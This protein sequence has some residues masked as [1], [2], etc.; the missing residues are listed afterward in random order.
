[1]ATLAGNSIASS[2]TSLLKLD[3]NTDSTAAGNG[4]NA[5]QVKTG[6]ND[7]TPLYLNTDRLG[8]GTANVESLLHVQSDTA[9]QI[10]IHNT[11]SGN[12]PKFLFD[13]L[14]GTNADYVLGSLRASWDTHTNIVSEIRFESGNDTSNKDDGQI[15]FWTSPS[16]STV[17]ERLR[18]DENGNI[19]VSNDNPIAKMDIVGTRTINLTN[20][21]SDDTNK[22]AVITHSQYDSGTETEG[23]M[24]MQGFSSSSTN[25]IDIGGGNS[26]HNAT[27][28]IKFHTAAD[29]T[30][31]TGTARMVIDNNS[32][33]SLSNNDGG[34]DNTVFG[35]LAG[36]ALT[37]DGD[38]NV[39]IGHEAG[40]DMTTGERNVVIGYQAGDKMTISTRSVAIG[41]GALGTED[42]GD[43]SI[44]IGFNALNQQNSDSNNETTGNVG[45]GVEAGFYNQTGQY[46]TLIGTGAGLGASGQSNNNNTAV[47]YASLNVVTTGSNNT[48]IGRLAGDA[49][50]SGSSNIVIG[51]SAL[52][53]ATTATLNVAIGGD[54]MSLVPASVAIQD[55]VAIGQNAFKGSASTTTGA[56]GIVAIGRDSLKSLTT[57]TENTA[58]GYQSADGLTTGGYNTFVGYKVANGGT[59]TGLENTAMGVTALQQLTS[60]GQNTAVGVRAGLAMATGS[61]NVFIGKDAGDSATACSNVIAIGHNA[62]HTVSDST[63]VDGTIAIGESALDALTSGARNLAIGYRSGTALTTQTDNIAIG[64]DSL[65]SLNT[66]NAARNIAIGSYAMENLNSWATDNIAIGYEA[67]EGS[68]NANDIDYNIA[69]GSYALD[70]IGNNGVGGCVAVGYNALTDVNNS[71]A[72]GTI[73]IGYNAGSNI[74]NGARNTIV[75]YEGMLDSAGAGDNAVFGY[76]VLKEGSTAE[77]QTAMGAYA[78]GAASAAALT[79]N[80][81]TAIGYKALTLLQGSSL[82]NTAVGSLTLENCTTG[83]KNTTLGYATMAQCV[84]TN[85]CVAIG[86]YAM[87]AGDVAGDGQVAVGYGA[88]GELTGGTKNTSLGYQAGNL[89]T[90]GDTNIVIGY[91]ADVDNNNRNGCIVIGCE[92]TLNTASDNVVEIG[93]DTNSMTYDLDGGD[94]T[95][96]SDVRTKMNIEDSKIGLD[97]I[98]SLRPVTYETK[99]SA[100]YPKEFGVKNPVKKKSGKKWDGLIAQE[101]KQVMDDMGVEFSGWSE[102]LNTKQTLAYG[103]LIMP[104]I[105]SVQELSAKVEELQSKLK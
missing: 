50:T 66:T 59:I 84:D 78:L 63:A 2:Y 51:D 105:K 86:R 82:E 27:E 52:G 11:S 77:R 64:Y 102:G 21:T 91:D 58:I 62:M 46:N 38:E 23:F 3:G 28:E 32:R 73:A 45:I 79:G 12:A 22:N 14:V 87:G 85:N 19:G 101:V 61:A 54:C 39:L 65:L 53:T 81:N 42:V 25:R 36:N 35:K 92:L 98:N 44:A 56:D 72:Y 69:I 9:A 41:Y 57:G 20:T 93:N 43:R 95:V 67:M 31:A 4:S 89:I 10:Q 26:Q 15:T 80:E 47:G 34:A 76:Q 5:I 24:L 33:I 96:T 40:N 48:V 18:I 55:V 30:T 49:I 37:T 97:F 99:P 1:M 88:L 8:I 68:G 60:G 70:D 104:L 7:A 83:Q 16:S 94:I 6:D 13:G 90:T 71:A 103:K 75:G 100:E 74:S 29:A 17:A